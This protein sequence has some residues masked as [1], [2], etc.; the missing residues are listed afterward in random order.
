MSESANVYMERAKRLYDQKE[1]ERFG[2]SPELEL[3]SVILVYLSLVLK[4]NEAEELLP[5]GEEEQMFLRHFCDS[6]QSLLLFGY[7]KRALVLDIG[8]GCGF[9]SIPIRLFRPD[10]S[11]LLVEPNRR[12]G[13]F[14]AEVKAE[15]GLDNVEI[16]IGKADNVVL[17]KKADYV[18][19]RCGGTLQKFAQVAKPHLAGDGRMYTHKTK[20]FP[21]ELNAITT[22]KDK[23][24]VRI[25][26]IAQY[27][28]GGA[29]Q[30][31]SLVS[32][33]FV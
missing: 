24:G 21:A 2:L 3:R 12:K 16:H 11:F 6:L 4:G 1:V 5:E 20:Q 31:L 14:L 30:G 19:S 26:E 25:R 7:K 15:L 9:P 29:I 17:E 32:M 10:I 8:A 22:S 23:D 33:E 28:L 13:E 27:D 18:V